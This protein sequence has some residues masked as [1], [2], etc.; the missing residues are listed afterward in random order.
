MDKTRLAGKKALIT[1]AAQ[2]MGAAIAKHWAAQGAEV[3]LGDLNIEGIKAVADEIIA[4]GGKATYIKL[5]V[6][7]EED[8]KAAVQ[9]TV[10]TFGEI[11]LLL[12]NAGI[13]KP[14]F[15]LDITK[16]N[17]D[18]L[19]KVNTWGSLNVMQKVAQ[20]M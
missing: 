11:N 10:D 13:N 14:L 12:N 3:C 6:A 18:L 5:D 15:F 9:H 4:D 7:S 8:A 17:F 1:G 20:Q 2:G 16:E 19:N